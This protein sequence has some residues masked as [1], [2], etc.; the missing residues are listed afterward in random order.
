MIV[1]TYIHSYIQ[2]HIQCICTIT[3]L[4]LD[5]VWALCFDPE[6]R[7]LFS[8]GVDRTIVV[9]DIGSHQGTAYE[10]NGH[11]LV[12]LFCYFIKCHLCNNSC[13]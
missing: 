4:L 9:W 1:H 12:V 10:L 3:L 7:I 13:N 5:S 8:G 11:L 2:V 6:R